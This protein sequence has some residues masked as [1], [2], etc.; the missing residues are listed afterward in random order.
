METHSY[1]NKTFYIPHNQPQSFPKLL[2]DLKAKNQLYN[3]RPDLQA[4]QDAPVFNYTPCYRRIKCSIDIL[5]MFI[6]IMIIIHRHFI[7]ILKPIAYL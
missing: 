4:N 7:T 5:R 6:Q 2:Q 1:I 3:Y